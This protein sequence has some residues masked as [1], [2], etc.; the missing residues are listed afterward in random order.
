MSRH[1]SFTPSALGP[2]LVNSKKLAIFP[3]KQRFEPYV[4]LGPPKKSV[5]SQKIILAYEMS[6]RTFE[7]GS[8]G[9]IYSS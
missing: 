5:E 3:F 1:T 8:K 6:A 7:L 4:R 9:E 2:S